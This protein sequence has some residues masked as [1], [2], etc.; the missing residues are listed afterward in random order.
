VLSV[1]VPTLDVQNSLLGLTGTAA[2]P[3]VLGRSLCSFSQGSSLSLAGRG[4]LPAS[5]RDP[6]WMNTEETADVVAADGGE[7]PADGRNADSLSA[8]AVIACR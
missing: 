1:T 6:L 5:A 7:Q 3:P 8:A 4:G 2:T